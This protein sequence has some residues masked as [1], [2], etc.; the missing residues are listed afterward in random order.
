MRTDAVVEVLEVRTVDPGDVL[1][2][3]GPPSEPCVIEVDLTARRHVVGRR[4]TPR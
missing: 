1:G 4:R 3:E 2:P